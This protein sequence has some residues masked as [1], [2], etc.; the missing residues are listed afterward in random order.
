[1]N[2]CDICKEWYFYDSHKCSPRWLVWHP[3]DECDDLPVGSY[4]T[5]VYADTANDAVVAY[6]EEWDSADSDYPIASDCECIYFRARPA[7]GGPVVEVCVSGEFTAEY[8]VVK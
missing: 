4:A 3:D 2:R 6:A 5:V 8:W 7:E 1:M